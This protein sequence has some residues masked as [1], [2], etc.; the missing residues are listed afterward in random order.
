MRFVYVNLSEGKI[1]FDHIEGGVSHK[2]LEGVGIAS[3][4]QVL[5]SKCVPEAV[6]MDIAHAGF[7]TESPQHLIKL[8]RWNMAI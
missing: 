1:S 7:A 3:V 2:L 5:D 8:R 6:R 4:T